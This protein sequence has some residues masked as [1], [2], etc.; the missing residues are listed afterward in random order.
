MAPKAHTN[1]S[2]SQTSN[3]PEIEHACD[4][5]SSQGKR[6][7]DTTN[8][9][10]VQHDDDEETPINTIEPNTKKQKQ[11]LST[12]TTNVSSSSINDSD[13]SMG[14]ITSS[15]SGTT[16]IVE[17]PHQK[18]QKPITLNF[19]DYESWNA[20]QVVQLLTSPKSLGGAGL[21]VEKVKPLYE[22][23]FDGSSLHNIV[24]D[25]MKKDE[26]FAIKAMTG[27]KDF[28]HISE[29]TCKTVVF[30]VLDQLI[31]PNTKLLY[32]PTTTAFGQIRS[33]TTTNW[34]KEKEASTN[35][36]D[37]T[38]ASSF[39]EP[40]TLNLMDY[41]KWNAQ[42]VASVLTSDE[43]LGGAGLSVE[44][45]KP[46]YEAGFDGSSLHNIVEDIMKKDEYFA[47]KA[48]TGSKDFTHISESTCKTVVFWVL[49]QLMTRQY[50]LWQLEPVSK[51]IKQKLG[52]P[53]AKGGADL[54]LDQVSSLDG[55]TL[56]SIAKDVVYGS[57]GESVAVGN[58]DLN[59]G[60]TVGKWVTQFLQNSI[61]VP[62]LKFEHTKS[63]N[64]IPDK[65]TNDTSDFSDEE[66][67]L[68]QK[69]NELTLRDLSHVHYNL[70]R[71][72]FDMMNREQAIQSIID[73]GTTQ[74]KAS[75][76]EKINKQDLTFLIV[77]GG[78]GSGKTRIV[79]EAVKIL[80]K[81]EP[82]HIF[83]NSSV[84][85]F[86]F[87]NGFVLQNDVARDTAIISLISARIIY[88]AFEDQGISRRLPK[89]DNDYFL[90]ELLRIISSKLH[91]Q[92]KVEQSVPIPLILAFDEYQRVTRINKD[93][94]TQLQHKIGWYM[95]NCQKRQGL[96][97]FPTFSGTL[98]DSD[99][100]FEP[101][102]YKITTL[103]LP[104]LR[105]EDIEKILIMQNL[106]E[107]YVSKYQIF[108]SIIGVVPRHL[109]WAVKY[110]KEITNNTTI[111]LE[112]KISY[113]YCNVVKEMYLIYQPNDAPDDIYRYLSLLTLSGFSYSTHKSLKYEKNIEVLAS[114]GRIYKSNNHIGLPLPAID[115]LSEFYT[116]IP[117]RLFNDF[118]YTSA[119]PD[120]E[121]F[122]ELC[123]K[124]ITCKLNYILKLQHTKPKSTF[125]IGE[126][127]QGA[128][129][130]HKLSQQTLMTNIDSKAYF[131]YAEVSQSISTSLVKKNTDDN[132]ITKAKPNQQGIDGFLPAF[133]LENEKKVLFV[134][135]NKFLKDE[136]QIRTL[137]PKQL[138]N[139]YKNALLDIEGYDVYVIIFSRKKVS[140]NT[141]NNVN[142]G[143]ISAESKQTPC[144]KLILVSGDCFDDF[145]HPFIAN[146]LRK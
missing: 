37:V 104:T 48:M 69:I 12:N 79:S 56:Y 111:P 126:L 41:K 91:E 144:P 106:T 52:E 45:V 57:T 77:K 72:I 51:Q 34:L 32:Y 132:L 66:L 6:K 86:N 134:V 89:I 31:V 27:S 113:I 120:W 40:I 14:A 80:S 1:I 101:T 109:E 140:D 28:T 62:L 112:T 42:Q 13:V 59:L 53:I 29:S 60:T 135:Q 99:A 129:M 65:Y 55:K 146:I 20:Q 74:Y 44:K 54:S 127:F 10:S 47:I 137:E 108:W 90:Y 84:I 115:K 49:D 139:H 116:E 98:L 68:L 67:L 121:K 119:K 70:D 36:N 131:H 3:C 96:V 63:S 97:L 25:I 142:N 61:Q 9:T 7:M 64:Y 33:Y 124:T 92:L 85:Y 21:S 82:Q 11:T 110:A 58:L 103:P 75:Q 125:T 24:E 143:V 93:L 128:H 117:K 2:Q 76:L 141:A 22:A 87:T 100:K 15:L 138:C 8:H 88:S 102:D 39:S 26:Y 130:P 35:D 5:S 122:E 107:F 71:L 118:I 73:L 133:S 94:N 17:E 43:S 136:S 105:K 38:S 19:T 145:F 18:S 46:L 78:S 81:A 95:R 123:L 30:W 4:D 83:K 16:T 50:S 114:E 23:G